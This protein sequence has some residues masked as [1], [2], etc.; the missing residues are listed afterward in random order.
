[1]HTN[2]ADGSVPSSHGR[3]ACLYITADVTVQ[4]AD[5]YGH[6]GHSP[7]FVP[8]FGSVL[9]ADMVSLGLAIAAFPAAKSHPQ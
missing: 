2:A 9:P 8:T 6:G 4:D 1:M 7:A 3:T 5:L